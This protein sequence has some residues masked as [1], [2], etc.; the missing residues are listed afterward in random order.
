MSKNGTKFPL[1][2]PF[3]GNRQMFFKNLNFLSHNIDD[4]FSALIF[5][6][7]RIHIRIS[8]FPDADPGDQNHAD[9]DPQHC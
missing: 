7:I 9:A 8:A 4:R 1:D 5:T 2:C 3:K 6:V